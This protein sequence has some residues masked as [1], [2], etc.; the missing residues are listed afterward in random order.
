MSKRKA[1]SCEIL[2]LDDHVV[3][4]NKPPGVPVV[5]LR[6]GRGI[7]LRGQLEEHLGGERVFVVHRLDRGTSG[8]VVFARDREAHRTLSLMFQQHE[9]RKSY[10]GV[11]RGRP[12]PAEGTIELAL[13][14]DRHNPTKM[15]VAARRGKPSRTDYRTL[16]VFRMFS[17]VALHPLTGR[18]HQ[19][20][21][22][23][24]AIGHPLAVDRLYGGAEAV[25]LS[26]FKRS[27][28]K[29]RSREERPL[30]SRLTLHARAIRLEQPVTGGGSVLFEAPL[31]HDFEVFLRQLAKHASAE[32]EH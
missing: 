1:P 6:S 21:V 25:Y 4:V 23:L 19:L 29:K 13:E 17:L 5:P 30:I 10:L 12:V 27:Y 15:C 7:S 2:H 31:P 24:R 14:Q 9:V 26:E 8:V 32:S 11:V 28:R 22:H 16:E 20:R 18:T 3:V